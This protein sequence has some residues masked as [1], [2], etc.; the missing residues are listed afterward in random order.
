MA[1]CQGPL[2]E[3][4]GLLGERVEGRRSALS[5]AERESS[6]DLATRGRGEGRGVPSKKKLR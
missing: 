5:M 2:R 4:Q 6:C 3:V 1:L